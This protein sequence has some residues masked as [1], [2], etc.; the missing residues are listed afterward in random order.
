MPD[1]DTSELE[2]VNTMLALI[3]EAPVNSL[4]TN[5]TA[6]VAMAKRTLEEQN[7]SLQVQGWHWNTD[8]DLTITPDV[9]GRYAWQTDWIRFDT[10]RPGRTVLGSTTRAQRT[11]HP[12]DVDITR[13]GEFLWNLAT[14]T[15]VFS[16]DQLQGH[17]VRYLA[18]ED[19][20]ESARTYLMIRAARIFL[21]RTLGDETRSGHAFQDEQRAFHILQTDETDQAE[22]NILTTGAW[23]QMIRRRRSR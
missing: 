18:W 8:R 1:I 12:A 10:E 20:P 3:G 16:Q 17:V 14:G 15:N 21:N 2:A 5:V 7:R 6:D 19:L 22:H 23:P 9:N 4:T 11:Y 13:R